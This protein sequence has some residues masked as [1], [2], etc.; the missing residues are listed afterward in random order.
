M[1]MREIPFEVTDWSTVERTE[2]LGAAG[3]AYWRTQTF[4]DV[5]VRIVEYSAGYLANHWCR[6]GHVVFCLE[7]S[8]ETELADGRKFELSPGQ[9]YQVGDDAGA[10]RSSTIS[11][12]RLL[13]VD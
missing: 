13:I 7:G 6:K 1:I 5:R 12:A 4:G 9:S 10:H 2:H 8:L 11:G 3:L